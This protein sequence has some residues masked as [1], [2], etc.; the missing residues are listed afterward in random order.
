MKFP[1][2]GFGLIAC[3]Q[4]VMSCVSLELADV[5]GQRMSNQSEAQATVNNNE[6]VL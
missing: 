6:S 3:V 1:V 5:K 2:D 4:D